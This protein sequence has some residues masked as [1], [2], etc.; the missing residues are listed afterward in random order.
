M[1]HDLSGMTMEELKKLQKDVAKAISN[2]EEHK[3]KE[4]LAAA[5]AAAR[6]LG[7]SLSELTGTTKKKSPVPAK[8]F[9]PENPS[10]TWTGRGRQPRWFKDALKSGKEEDLLLRR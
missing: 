7:Y 3:K 6:E 1:K 5:D 9:N 2:F 10:L 4:A 8:Y